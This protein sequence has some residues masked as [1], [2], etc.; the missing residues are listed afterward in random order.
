MGQKMQVFYN[1]IVNIGPSQKSN[2][3]KPEASSSGL[4][5]FTDFLTSQHYRLSGFPTFPLQKKFR[6]FVLN[7]KI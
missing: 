5:D 3:K 1:E 6:S 7:W 4:S 2:S